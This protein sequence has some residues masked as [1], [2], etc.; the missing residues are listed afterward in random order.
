M[1]L[2]EQLRAL[3]NLNTKHWE[4]LPITSK[5]DKI[6][7]INMDRENESLAPT[8]AEVFE[9]NYFEY[10]NDRDAMADVFLDSNEL[11]WQ[12]IQANISNN[13]DAALGRIIRKEMDRLAKKYAQQRVD[14][15]LVQKQMVWKEEI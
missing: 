9:E 1:T 6:E 2:D 7:R 13:D 11:T 12:A 8:E 4:L 14:R 15:M 3:E 10:L 5:C